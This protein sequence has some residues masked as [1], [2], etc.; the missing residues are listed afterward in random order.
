[1]KT[2]EQLEA[3][4][5]EKQKELE[6][7][8]SKLAEVNEAQQVEA[9]AEEQTQKV[10]ARTE[11]YARGL[12]AR[13]MELVDRKVKAAL[14]YGMATGLKD[15][16]VSPRILMPEGLLRHGNLSKVDKQMLDVVMGRKA[17]T[18]TGGTAGDEWVP[19]ELSNNLLEMV[20]IASS[21]RGFIDVIDMPSNPF[22]VPVLSAHMTLEYK[23]ESATPT[24][25][26]PTTGASTL[27]AKKLI[28]SV[29]FSEELV[30]DSIVPILPTLRRDCATAAALA[31]EAVT[32]WGDDT[33]TAASNIDK[34]V[35][36]STATHVQQ[37]YNGLWYTVLNG[38][39]TWF[40]AYGTSWATSI[41]SMRA[42]MAKY[43]IVP[44][45]MLVIVGPAVYNLLIADSNFLTME[46]VGQ[47]AAIL[48]GRLPN[49]S[50][51]RPY[52]MFD[53]M[54]V[55]VSSYMYDTDASGV[56]LTTAASN[57]KHSVLMVN[58]R[59]VL[60]GQRRGI[61]LKMYDY[62]LYDTHYLIVSIRPAL[63]LPDGGTTGAY[64]GI[65]NG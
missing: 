65:Y 30:E 60:M 11:E 47:N 56:R 21:L 42:A 8:N 14:P 57:T 10:L 61:T 27:T 32:L 16:I 4:L 51:A 35:V 25:T 7:A 6:A 1:M 17:M 48:T 49:P 55:T 20:D 37:A 28:G 38:T 39:A 12:D 22:N 26:N 9:L 24:G 64:G 52:G 15:L 31:E 3:E 62:A 59:R 46:K 44:E 50:A 18:S 13:V 45:D 19:T 29:Q 54:W 36:D 58:R 34:N 41:R 2:K 63:A 53:G 23:G 33:T 5:A 40:A 43:A